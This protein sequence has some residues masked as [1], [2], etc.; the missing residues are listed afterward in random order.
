MTAAGESHIGLRKN[1]EDSY[2]INEDCRLLVIADG[3]G[4]HEHGQLASEL[5]VQ[6]FV[7]LVDGKCPEAFSTEQMETLF[8]Q[9][10]KAV[11]E[12]QE[13]L[14][15]GIMGTTLTVAMVDGNRLYTGHVGDS[16]LYLLRDDELTQLTQ[17]HSYYAEL[18]RQG[19]TDIP[20]EN[21]QKNVL[22]KALGPEETI[23]GQYFEEKLYPDDQ[24][25][26]CTDGLYNAVPDEDIKQIMEQHTA[27]DAVH[28]LI[29][30][31]LAKGA[32]D[33]ITVIIYRH[34]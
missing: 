11:Y 26:L 27:S 29:E 16:R 25:L 15:S 3:M 12:K 7:T 32:T 20:L 9:A 28:L 2:Y 21:R 24:L 22:L 19:N 30:T 13:A 14:Q 31:A 33:N 4:G 10:N 5:A 8:E 17:D 6:Q 34:E 1:N 23:S 18:M